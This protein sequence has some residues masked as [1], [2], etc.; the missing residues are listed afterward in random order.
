MKFQ[1][2]A[3]IISLLLLASACENDAD[4]VASQADVAAFEQELKQLQA[5][6]HIPGMAVLVKEGDDIIYENYFGYADLDA[7]TPVTAETLFPIASVSKIFGGV[8]I[9]QL[10]EAGKLK[11]DDPILQYFPNAPIPESV[12]IQHVLSHTSQGIPG[13]HF[14]YSN[15]FGALTKAVEKVSKKNYAE[16]VQDCILTPLEMTQSYPFGDITLL[17][18]VENLAKPYEY[19]GNTREGLYSPGFSTATGIVTNVRDLATFDDALDANE[20]ISAAH[21]KQMFTPFEEGMPYG[22]GVFTQNFM[23]EKLVWGYGQ[24]NCFSSLFL[25]LPGRNLTFIVQANNRLL[26]DPARLINGD[27]TYSLFALNF[28]KHFAFDLPTTLRFADFQ[29]TS[30]IAEFYQNLPET[31]TAFYRQELLANALVASFMGAY[32]AAA[33]DRSA[34]LLRTAFQHFPDYKSYGN[35]S[36]MHNLAF[37]FA[38]SGKT[39][40]TEK[41]VALGQHLLETYPE[42]SYVNYYLGAYFDTTGDLERASQHFRTILDAENYDRNWYTEDAEQ[43]FE[44]QD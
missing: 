4:S 29:D 38:F 19:E 12:E 42:N 35:A 27:V 6:F 41:M 11:L 7:Q 13:E 33:F 21:K 17:D 31:D 10:V 16:Y 23:N 40:F 9:F 8:S 36:L 24:E 3:F 14:L 34:A 26:S 30:K 28:L 39:D 18:T 44:N 25:K 37:L 43:F 5:Y 2:T 20:L 22:L 15:R 32:N 1:C